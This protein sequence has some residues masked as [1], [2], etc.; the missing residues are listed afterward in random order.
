MGI[1]FEEWKIGR[2]EQN[3]RWEEE[4][5]ASILGAE[6][7]A[8]T[9]RAPTAKPANSLAVTFSIGLIIFTSLR[10]DIH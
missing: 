10:I 3:L 8:Q 1:S 2:I 7:V 5:K 4:M 6:M 9:S